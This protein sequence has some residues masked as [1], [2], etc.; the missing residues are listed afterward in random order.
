M[1]KILFLIPSLYGGGAEK[2][3]CLLA[4]G[5]AESCRVTVGYLVEKEERYPLDPRCDTVRIPWE[6]RPLPGRL[7]ISVLFLRKLKK[8]EGFDASVSFLIS[9][10]YMNLFSKRGERVVVSERANPTKFQQG[11]LWLV[12]LIY[13]FADRVVFQSETVKNLFGKKTRAH[14]VVIRNPV[15]ISH[16]ALPE[17][18]HRIVTAGRLEE[19]KNHSMLIR[20]FSEFRKTHPAYTLSIYGEGSLREALDMQIREA[21][22]SDCVFLE[23]N[24]PAWHAQIRNAEMFV[25]SSNFEGLSNAL[26]ECMTMG[27]ACISTACEGSSDVIRDG[28][29]GLLVPVGDAKALRD[30]MCRFADDPAFRKSAEIAAK[31]DAAAFVPAKIVKEWE[32]VCFA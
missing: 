17:R 18:R 31:A 32:E 15:S 21:G 3:C 13:R 14:G 24:D 29:N 16:T 30:A 4:S 27:I 28:E 6:G 25:L 26:L 20:S 2:V 10:N 5:M 1:R 9:C 7:L 12:R 22:L 23:G 19:Q 8:K 11:N